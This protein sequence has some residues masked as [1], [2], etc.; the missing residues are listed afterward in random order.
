MSDVSYVPIG[1]APPA[2]PNQYL[3]YYDAKEKSNQSKPLFLSDEEEKNRRRD[4][5]ELK[6][7][8]E[9]HRQQHPAWEKAGNFYNIIQSGQG[10][11][12]ISRF[13][14]GL[15]RTIIDT[16]IAMINEGEPEGSFKPIGPGDRKISVL[17]DALT[18]H[19]LNKCNWRAHQKLWTTDLHIFGSSPLEAYINPVVRRPNESP[20]L[21]M[22]RLAKTPRVGLRHRSI[23]YTYRNANVID[24]DDVPSGAW[25]ETITHADWVVRFAG[26]KD[27]LNVDKIPVASKYKLTTIANELENTLRI[28]CLPFGTKAEADYEQQPTDDELGVPVLNKPLTSH[29]PLGMVPMAFGIFNDQLTPDFKQHS[30]YGMGIPQLIEGMELIM[31]GLFNMTVDNMRLK[32]TVPVGYQPYQGQTDFPD[33]DNIGVLESGRV[34]GGTFSP[35]SLGIAD[36]QSNTVLWEWINNMC[37]WLTGYNFQQLGGDTSNTAFEFAQRLKANSNRALGRLKGLENGP[38]DRAWTMLLANTLGQIRKDEWENIT[39][40]QAQDIAELIKNGGA[41]TDDYTFDGGQVKSK[42]FVEYFEV[43]DFN[44]SENFSSSKKRKLDSKRAD[45]TLEMREEKGAT[46]LAPAVA[47]YLFP[48]GDIAQMMA[49]TVDVISKTMLGDLRVKDTDAINNALTKGMELMQAVPEITSKM[50]FEL[51]KQDAETAGLDVDRVI[52]KAEDSEILTKVKDIV[53]G[54][55]NIAST[56]TD[57]AQAMA[58]TMAVPAGASPAPTQSGPGSTTPQPNPV[59]QQIAG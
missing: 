16:G 55:E 51:W 41:S 50:M 15:S 56:P 48:N 31:E 30:L 8:K 52:E 7:M 26:R 11:D 37:I 3:F 14:V 29:N 53:S 10:H 28:Y 43:P 23:W 36:L 27:I 32:N 42:R 19:T 33:L 46:S 57:N 2:M 45:N 5:E 20:E 24:P 38:L 59:L 4:Y 25:E 12:D 49:F 58:P 44:I 17:W 54:M 18:K 9:H 35:T 40:T 13:A 1:I 47:E 6:G 39:E 34:Y 21:F 22:I